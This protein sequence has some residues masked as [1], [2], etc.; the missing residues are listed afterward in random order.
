[1]EKCKITGHPC[2]TD[3]WTTEN[4]TCC[5]NCKRWYQN[6]LEE[7][8]KNDNSPGDGSGAFFDTL[9]CY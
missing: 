5:E 1:M 4:P 6:T 2:G 9:G 8:R 3:T 7:K